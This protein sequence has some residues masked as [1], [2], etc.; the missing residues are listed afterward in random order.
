[1]IPL[2]APLTTATGDT[3]SH[4]FVRKGTEVRVP[5]SCL[6][7]SEEFW[8]PTAKE[9]KPE[10]WLDGGMDVLRSKEIHGH[11]HLLTFSDGPRCAHSSL[12]HSV[13]EI[14]IYRTCIG[15]HFAL[16]N[17]KIILYVLIRNFVFEFP[18]G[19]DTQIE[20]YVVLGAQPKVAGAK[21]SEV[22]MYVK[23]VE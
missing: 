18:D 11:R 7:L 23:R 1:V 21:G 14:A 13:S 17:F 4:I 2:G 6:N 22:P 10:R 3:V 9:F 12:A 20:S 15:K 5:G 19:P 16:N 8:G